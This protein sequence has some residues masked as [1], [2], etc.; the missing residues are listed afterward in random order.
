MYVQ[1]KSKCCKTF[2][3]NHNK[4]LRTFSEGTATESHYFTILLPTHMKSAI[5]RT[6]YTSKIR[7]Q[8]LRSIRFPTIAVSYV[9]H[10]LARNRYNRYNPYILI[11]F[12][13]E[14]VHLVKE[15][16]RQKYNTLDDMVNACA[17]NNLHLVIS[18]GITQAHWTTI[19][20]LRPPGRW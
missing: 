17:D 16:I 1:A 20:V 18:N 15:T 2:A 10:V 4:Y 12:L 9:L 6:I 3:S 19:V 5:N 8:K 11:E 7:G 14:Q 13:L